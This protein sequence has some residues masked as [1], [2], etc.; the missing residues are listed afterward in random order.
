MPNGLGFKVNEEWN[1]VI[2][3][4]MC[5]EIKVGTFLFFEQFRIPAE[6]GNRRFAVV[7][8]FVR[9]VDME[10]KVEGSND[11]GLLQL[12]IETHLSCQVK[13]HHVDYIVINPII[14]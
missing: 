12:G 8:C 4:N 3:P 9:P 5:R 7:S 14:R 13:H 11:S 2:T 6:Q 10:L 1:P